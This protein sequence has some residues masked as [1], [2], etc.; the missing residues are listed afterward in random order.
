MV[1]S[2]I[3][4]GLEDLGTGRGIVIYVGDVREKRL[5]HPGGSG[6]GQSDVK[7]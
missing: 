7:V 5:L 3:L 4:L 2:A 1:R 6:L